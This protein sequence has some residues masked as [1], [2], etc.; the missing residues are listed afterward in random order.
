MG[1]PPAVPGAF[2]LQKDR[3]SGRFNPYCAMWGGPLTAERKQNIHTA[4]LL[5][6]RGLE[7]A[8]NLLPAEGQDALFHII[9]N[10]VCEGLPDRIRFLTDDGTATA[11]P[12]KSQEQVQEDQTPPSDER[13]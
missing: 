5:E 13:A 2:R 7:S 4:L 10:T 1:K 12:A 11:Q 9:A 6:L 3:A 8:M